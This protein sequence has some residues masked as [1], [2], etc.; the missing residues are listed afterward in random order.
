L[1]DLGCF[2]LY[3]TKNIMCGEGGI[4]TTN[5][6]QFYEKAKLFRNHGQSENERYNYH[7]LGYNYRLTDIASAI[8]VKQVKKLTQYTKR[9]QA[10]AKKY[11]AAFS[12][13]DGIRIPIV[14]P[15]RIHVFHQYTIIVTDESKL[16]RDEL[17]RYLQEKNIQTNIYY[18]KPLNE[19][20]HFRSNGKFPF[21]DRAAKQVLSIPVH[22]QLT[23]EQ[24]D[25]II[26]TL[27]NI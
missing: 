21:A 27:S 15:N 25:Y 14:K 24:I 13:L 23:D 17:Q 26:S 1:G 10:I 22:P 4:V 8:G 3:A 12:G 19:F 11:N 5:S 6:K 20:D 18:P 2:S 16:S 7:S 9:R